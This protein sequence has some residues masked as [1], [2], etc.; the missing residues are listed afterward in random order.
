MSIS[1]GLL[2]LAPSLV[3]LL[4][5]YDLRQVLGAYVNYKPGGAPVDD[6]GRLPSLWSIVHA[7]VSFAASFLVFAVLLFPQA[8]RRLPASLQTSA[9]DLN[10]QVLARFFVIIYL[11][12]FAGALQGVLEHV[13]IRWMYPILILLPL[14]YFVRVERAGYRA[15]QLRR[16]QWLLFAWVGLT[17]VLWALQPVAR[18]VL[19]GRCRLFEPYPALATSIAADAGDAVGTIVAADEHIAGNVR[20]VFPA[21]RVVTP[22]Y[23]FYVPALPAAPCLIVWNAKEGETIPKRLAKF[24]ADKVGFAGDGRADGFVSGENRANRRPLRLGYRR[25]E[26]CGPR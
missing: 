26:P 25:V 3:W 5:E 10:G 12:L 15:E 14:Y 17:V 9:S 16:W 24:A 22:I 1:I 13:K 4:R 19:C 2:A 6:G 8:L 20:P 7:S 23:P 21:A 18:N 11:L